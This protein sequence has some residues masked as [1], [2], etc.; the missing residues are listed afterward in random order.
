ML[1][2][3]WRKLCSDTSICA[4]TGKTNSAHQHTK[5]AASHTLKALI[6]VAVV[7]QSQKGFAKNWPA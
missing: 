4:P 5:V 2:A 7:P 1:L 6:V 3:S